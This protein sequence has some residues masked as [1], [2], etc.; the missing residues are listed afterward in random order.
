[1]KNVLQLNVEDWRSK[2]ANPETQIKELFRNYNISTELIKRSTDFEDLLDLILE[3]YSNRLDE[4]PGVD[5]VNVDKLD[6]KWPIRE[7]LRSLIMF[8]SQAVLL[9][10]NAVVFNKLEDSNQQ[11]AELTRKLDKKN[12]KLKEINHQYLN[13][14]SFVAHELRSP[15]ISVLGFAE[16]LDE[17]ALGSLNDEQH[18]AVQVMIRSSRTLI[19]MI[20]NYLDLSKIEQGEL[21]LDKKKLDL[22]NDVLRFVLEEMEEQF[23]RAELSVYVESEVKPPQVRCDPGLIRVVLNNLL[24]N[25]IK[26]GEQEGRVI[27]QLSKAEREL[28]VAV[29]NS[30][31]G[32]AKKELEKLFQ[33]FTQIDNGH[34]KSTR[35]SGLGLYN[36]RY[37]IKK[38][39]GKIWADSEM[40]AWF[41][42]TFTLPN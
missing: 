15:L 40:G 12:A 37:I 26:Y 19:D 10:E 42:V 4:M 28:Q 41:R 25:A 13:M 24:S 3:E 31:E 6:Q 32:M 38:H 9:K 35:S 7:K 36:S 33:K 20:Q 23:Q 8:A 22:H 18:R 16:L 34:K 1:M 2:Y 21:H 14:L 27:I 17:Q 39:G 29:T 30:G 11:L 5:L